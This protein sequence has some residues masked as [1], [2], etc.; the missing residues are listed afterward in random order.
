[1]LLVSVLALSLGSCTDEYE[2]NGVTVG[3]E[4]V[5]FSS[6]IGSTVELPKGGGEEAKTRQIPVNRINRK[7]DKTVQIKI[8]RAVEGNR[9]PLTI[10]TP[11]SG[12]PASP[13]YNVAFADVTFADGD[14]VAYINV[15]YKD[16]EL[17][18]GVYETVTMSIT[19][20]ELT[21]P[22]GA[23]SATFSLGASEWKSMTGKATYREGIFSA[24]YGTD[25]M[26]Y[27]VDIQENVNTPGKYRIVA[28]Y[29]ENSDFYKAY[30]GSPFTLADKSNTDIVID[31]SDPDFVY[32]TGEFSPGLDDGMSSQGQGVLNVFSMVDDLLAAG[33]TLDRIKSAKPELFG[34]LKNGVITFPAQVLA[35][36]FDANPQGLY[37]ANSDM[38]AVAL[39]GYVIADYSS[40][41]TYSGR[42]TDGQNKDYAMGTITL[43]ADVASAKYVVAADGDD[44]SY[45]I[46]G[47]SDGSVEAT[48]ITAGGNVQVPLE[49]TG[50]YTMV[51]VTFG[52][53]GE[54]KGSSA[55][56]F[57][58]TS[59][60]DGG[61]G[62]A[63]WQPMYSGIFYYNVQ[64]AF[65][66]DQNKQPVGSLYRPE[67]GG[68][69]SHETV[70]YK[71]AAN[72]GKYKIAPWANTEDGITF[73]MD[74][75]GQISFIDVNTGSAHDQ[76]GAIYA[77]DAALLLTGSL[78]GTSYYAS[79]DGASQFVFG[80]V[81]Y[82]TTIQQGYMAG[83]Y[84]V[85]EVTGNA[86]QNMDKI[87]AIE[88]NGKFDLKLN[89]LKIRNGYKP[90][91]KKSFRVKA[92]PA[93]GLK[94]HAK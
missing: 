57:S 83:S 63:D 31:A 55:T 78:D 52:A 21:S 9:L 22:Y 18:Y 74:D 43:G 68:Q 44:I 47:I 28:P 75:G 73:T 88:K 89:N 24:L 51:I 71:D 11:V 37:Y 30:A 72:P 84:E 20:Q 2:Y 12:D 86:R 69:V 60:S 36:Y 67:D 54:A 5:Y 56:E 70:M 23:S 49:D 19:D 29:G 53:D 33:N 15:S 81:Y 91:I 62:S 61:A 80:T 27:S 8:Q 32:V 59:S 45:I 58:F 93:S 38:L 94:R 39:P 25:V 90:V 66:V 4:Q 50:K 7:G 41:F 16:S 10:G 6:N 3:G 17:N 14:S 92:K 85:F 77:A 87:R 48:Q 76:Y 64:P 1:M 65:I 26:S 79:Q 34:K 13:D 82:V 35:G 42:F 46:S 40:S